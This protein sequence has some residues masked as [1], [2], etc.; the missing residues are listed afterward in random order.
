MPQWT[1]GPHFSSKQFLL[2][3]TESEK[4]ILRLDHLLSLQRKNLILLSNYLEAIHPRYYSHFVNELKQLYTL[5]CS[6]L[7]GPLFIF[8][9]CSISL[10]LFLC[11]SFLE[12]YSSLFFLTHRYYYGTYSFH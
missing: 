3:C 4:P 8:N 1:A 6:L 7:S 9:L 2:Y 11:E 12:L 10:Y 5:N